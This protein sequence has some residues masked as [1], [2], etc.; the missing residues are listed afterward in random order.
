MAAGHNDCVC[1]ADE[2]RTN[3][4]FAIS[5]QS[6][7]VQNAPIASLTLDH[8]TSFQDSWIEEAYTLAEVVASSRDHR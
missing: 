5:R 3:K 2:S 1:F 4:A 7:T 6:Y 8:G